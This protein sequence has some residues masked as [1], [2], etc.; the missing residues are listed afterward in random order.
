MGPRPS[1]AHTLDRYPD[2]D[3][4][5]E[6]SNCRWA[7]WKEQGHSSRGLLSP[8]VARELQLIRG[9]MSVAEAVAATDHMRQIGRRNH[10]HPIEAR[11]QGRRL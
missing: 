5:Y 4:N 6:P 9:G 10:V 3:G 7:T 11:K 8:R 1:P 2:P